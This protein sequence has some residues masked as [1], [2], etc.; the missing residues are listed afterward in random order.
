MPKESRQLVLSIKK[1]SELKAR[2]TK[3]NQKDNRLETRV[4][5]Q[6]ECI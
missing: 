2:F 6:F 4:N 3:N 5:D 1:E